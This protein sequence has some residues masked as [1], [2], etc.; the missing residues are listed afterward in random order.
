MI[1]SGRVAEDGLGAVRGATGTARATRTDRE[2]VLVVPTRRV[3]GDD[4]WRGVRTDGLEWYGALI[5]R[6]GTF[7]LRSEVEEDPAW[8]QVIPYLVLRD[9]ARLFL[10][11]RTR[12]GADARLHDRYSIGV[13]GHINPGDGGVRGGLE[14][15]WREELDADF[16]PEFRPLGLLNADDDPVGAVHLGVVYEADAAGRRVAVRETDKLRGEFVSPDEVARVRDRL[17]TW[18]ALLFDFLVAPPSMPRRE[19]PRSDQG[20]RTGQVR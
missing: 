1:A 11:Q 5:E 8:K 17:E 19:G 10:M 16:E 18:S 9:G 13:G 7:R 14:R 15:E 20:G 4:P 6:E 12:G 3:I 2:A